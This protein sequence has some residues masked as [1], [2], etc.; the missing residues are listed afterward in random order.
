MYHFSV[1]LNSSTFLSISSSSVRRFASASASSR[2]A[3]IV[4]WRASSLSRELLLTVVVALPSVP[5]VSVA[6]LPVPPAS[7][8]AASS[9]VP[10]A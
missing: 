5:F 8:V 9:T 4:R 2:L 7:S 3:S 6:A 1:M 10:L